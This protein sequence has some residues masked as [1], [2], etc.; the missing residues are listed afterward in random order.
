MS[1]DSKGGGINPN[2]PPLY[3]TFSGV[4][5]GVCIYGRGAGR[6]SMSPGNAHQAFGFGDEYL[7]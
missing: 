6:D 4:L 5:I 2:T 3:T 1:Q 7:E